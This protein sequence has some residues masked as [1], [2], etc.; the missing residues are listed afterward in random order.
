MKM[1]LRQLTNDQRLV[2]MDKLIDALGYEISV[3][4]KNRRIDGG[5][6]DKYISEINLTKK[7]VVNETKDKS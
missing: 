3:V 7:E 1:S 6:E 4:Y 5:F 2:I